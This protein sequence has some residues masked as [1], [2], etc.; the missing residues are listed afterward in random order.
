[1]SE[2]KHGARGAR[3][4]KP[5]QPDKSSG[6]KIGG[7]S[8]DR[9]VAPADPFAQQ[10]MLGA[11]IGEGDLD[12]GAAVAGTANDLAF[13]AAGGSVT[14]ALAPEAVKR[15]CL[16]IDKSSAFRADPKVPLVIPETS[17][18]RPPA[19]TG[20][21]PPESVSPLHPLVGT[22]AATTE[23]PTTSF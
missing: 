2:W 6:G 9:H 23:R 21:S 11:E 22:G 13:F 12:A 20:I 3:S 18:T 4:A 8:M 1:M 17:F 19:A 5:V 15:G 10:H 16:C 14:K 7:H